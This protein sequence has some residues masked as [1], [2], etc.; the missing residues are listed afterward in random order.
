MVGTAGLEPATSGPP[1]QRANQAAPR[2]D[3]AS[4]KVHEQAD[5]TPRCPCRQRSLLLPVTQFGKKK[6]GLLQRR[7]LTLCTTTRGMESPTRINHRVKRRRRVID[8]PT[9]EPEEV[10]N[11][12]LQR[13]FSSRGASKGL[14]TPFGLA[15]K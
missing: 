3:W 13:L 8:N 11:A 5:Y 2:P 10:G 15:G 1:D 4:C 6:E 7:R 12:L 9:I 14:K